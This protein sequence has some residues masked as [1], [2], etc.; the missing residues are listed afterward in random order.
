MT[1][2]VAI[3]PQRRLSVMPY[4]EYAY[5]D[6]GSLVHKTICLQG[7]ELQILTPAGNADTEEED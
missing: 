5:D 4:C 1:V 2:F 7:K 3:E 6:D